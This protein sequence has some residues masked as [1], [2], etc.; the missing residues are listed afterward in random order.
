MSRI[1]CQC[2]QVIRILRTRAVERKQRSLGDAQERA[3]YAELCRVARINGLFPR[4]ILYPHGFAAKRARAVVARFLRHELGW[5]F[6]AV[7][8]FLHC[9]HTTAIYAARETWGIGGALSPGVAR[10]D[11][12]G[13]EAVQ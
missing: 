1:S 9:H 7:A 5:K 13:S 4:Q 12:R 11:L 6:I 10:R 2:D 3:A 8:E